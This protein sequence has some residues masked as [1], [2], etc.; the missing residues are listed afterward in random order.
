MGKDPNPLG[1]DFK[2]FI[3][4]FRILNFVIPEID[5]GT[6]VKALLN[7]FKISIFSKFAMAGGNS[8]ILLWLRVNL[9]IFLMFQ[10]RDMS[11]MWTRL[12]SLKSISAFGTPWASSRV[13]LT[14]FEV[15]L[16]LLKGPDVLLT[17]LTYPSAAWCSRL[18]LSPS[19][20]VM[21][22]YGP[23]SHATVVPLYAPYFFEEIF[24][25]QAKGS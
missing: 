10:R 14:I 7:K 16:G 2:R 9:V 12:L 20:A 13:F 15:I 25:R 23:I 5:A 17:W 1:K 8:E 6:S 24:G 21:N 22:C 3:P 18:L 11:S 19:W 4:R